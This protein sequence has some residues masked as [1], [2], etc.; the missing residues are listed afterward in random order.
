MKKR[1]D[2]LKMKSESQQ[3]VLTKIKNMTLQNQ[4]EYWKE[5]TDQLRNRQKETILTR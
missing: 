5:K 4:V 3:K 2:C 1:F